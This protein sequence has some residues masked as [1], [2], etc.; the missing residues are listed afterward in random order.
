MQSMHSEK[1]RAALLDIRDNIDRIASFTAGLT[2]ASFA[3]SDMHVYAVT[4]ALEIISEA[5]RRLPESMLARHT[6]LPWRQI[7][8]A[9]N[10]YRHEYGGVSP[11]RV[12]TTVT[13]DLS[14]LRAVVDRELRDGL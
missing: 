1:T 8:G 5:S 7:M 3:A 4:R 12:W 10:I 9:G 14:E 13:C 2:L 11:E 6:D